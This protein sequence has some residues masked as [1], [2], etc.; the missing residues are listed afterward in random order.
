MTEEANIYAVEGVESISDLK[1]QFPATVTNLRV[2]HCND[3]TSLS[4]I[5]K[6]PLVDLNLSSNSL[7]SMAGVE[8]LY[9]L[10][11]LNL[12]C[13]KLQSITCLKLLQNLKTLIL[14]H[15]RITCLRALE[16]MGDYSKL[17]CLDVTDNYI[18]ELSNIKSLSQF[19]HLKELAFRL[20]G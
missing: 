12:S 1:S 6:L 13:N 10:R 5:Q 15:N 4:G 3:L 18:T 19:R 17:E 20:L 16:E 2:M 9:K 7:L 8:G 14:S 11:Y